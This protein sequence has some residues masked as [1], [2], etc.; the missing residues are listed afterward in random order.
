MNN[1]VDIKDFILKIEHDFPVN[2]WKIN[3]IHL[4]PY[5]RINLFF[6]L[7]N[8]V[9][10]IK[11]SKE[12]N[13]I[14][15]GETFFKKFLLFG[16]SKIN[17][18]NYILNYYYFIKTIP[19]RE[20]VFLSAFNYRTN[21]NGKQFNKF[22]DAY[23]DE[24]KLKGKAITLEF[25]PEI[26][27]LYNSNS[28]YKFKKAI[29][30]FKIL[31]K[32][33]ELEFVEI[34]EYDKFIS[35]LNQY[36][37]LS[38]FIKTHSEENIKNWFKDFARRITFFKLLFKKINPKKIF[39][40][41]YYSSNDVYAMVV[42]AN[43][44]GIETVE[45]QHGP[46]TDIHLCYGNWSSLPKTGYDLLP[47]TYWCWDEHSKEV[48]QSWSKSNS[49]YSVKL[50]GNP[51][52]EY[53][54]KKS[55]K[56]KHSNYILYTLQPFPVT[57]N[58]LFSDEISATIKNSEC[59]WF[60]RLHPRQLDK[61]EELILFLKEKGIYN[62]VEID[63]ATNDSLPQLIANCLLHVTHFSGSTIEASL[64]NKYSVV[65]NPIALNSFPELIKNKKAL[66]INYQDNNFQSKFMSILDSIN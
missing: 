23:Y 49:L 42:A 8:H 13:N 44:L 30:G 1:R 35:F 36:D 22:F 55:D 10:G 61:K 45:M 41:C 65:V 17:R 48:I 66:Y 14:K 33:N 12:E 2:S 58:Q 29:I 9:E 24:N 4:W 3:T 5:I 47:K 60:L 20:I 25:G 27:Q 57:F 11:K 6:Y 15:K 21:H 37:I 7:M 31:N 19:S 63:A 16:K 28:V 18:L 62:N 54:K 34:N 38:D 39:F 59:K 26:K 40:L 64:F 32:L 56:Y 52:I 51:W 43:Q 46:Q 50:V 53:W